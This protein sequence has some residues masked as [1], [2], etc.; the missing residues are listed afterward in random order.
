MFGGW[1]RQLLLVVHNCLINGLA[2]I[3]IHNNLEIFVTYKIDKASLDTNKRKRSVGYE[4]AMYVPS[5]IRQPTAVRQFVVDAFMLIENVAMVSVAKNTVTSTSSYTDAFWIMV[6]VIGASYTAAMCLKLVYYWSCHPWS[7]LIKPR[8]C[9][10]QATNMSFIET[11]VVV[12]SKQVNITAGG[13]NG[14]NFSTDPTRDQIRYNE[15]LPRG[16]C[17]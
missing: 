5:D 13:S 15:M 12:L 10:D 11:S 7:T 14:V 6:A 4:E 1:C 3:Y 16:N 2:N 8:R 17:A 9:S